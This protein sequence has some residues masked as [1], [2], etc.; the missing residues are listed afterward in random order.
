VVLKRGDEKCFIDQV[1]NEK[2]FGNQVVLKRDNENVFVAL[3]LGREV[4]RES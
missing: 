3:L 2:Y 4:I 1:V